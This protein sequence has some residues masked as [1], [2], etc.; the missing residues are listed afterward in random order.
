VFSDLTLLTADDPFFGLWLLDMQMTDWLIRSEPT[1]EA[2]LFRSMPID[3]AF[4][5][6]IEPYI[7]N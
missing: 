2:L 6:S 1:R 7:W 3:P 4:R 5:L